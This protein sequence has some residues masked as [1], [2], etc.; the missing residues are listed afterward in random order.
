[1]FAEQ[2]RRAVEATPRLELTK[3]SALLWKAV[4]AGQVSEAEASALSETIEARRALPAI[5]RPVQRR[6][7]SRPRSPGLNGPETEMGL[8]WLAAPG[9]GCQVHPGRAGGPGR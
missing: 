4:A 3:V 9:P 7:G 8:L 6:V 1:M 2:L 5:S